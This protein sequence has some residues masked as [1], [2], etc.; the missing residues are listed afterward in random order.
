MGVAPRANADNYLEWLTD[1]IL[2]NQIDL[3]V[4]TSE[5][6]IFTISNNLSAIK[7]ICKVLIN[8]EVLIKNSLDKNKTLKYLNTADKGARPRNSWRW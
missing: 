4:P 8:D 5:A 6:E 2:T 7:S 1:Y 3:F